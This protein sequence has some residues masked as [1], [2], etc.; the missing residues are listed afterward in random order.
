MAEFEGRCEAVVDVTKPAFEG[1]EDFS[2]KEVGDLGEVLARTYLEDNGY[3]LV[4]ANWRTPFGEVDIIARS[5]DETIFVE[6]K[7]RR[8]LGC[9]L[10]DGHEEAPEEAVNEEKFERYAKMAEFYRMIHEEG[11]SIRFDVIGITFLSNRI[12]H[13]KH[14]QGGFWWEA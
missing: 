2:T 1:I 13:I 6:V 7:S 12:A 3:E 8:L 11:T 9:S 5:S 14:L 4:D 10:D